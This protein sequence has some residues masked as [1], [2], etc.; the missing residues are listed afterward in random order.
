MGR[1]RVSRL[2]FDLL[3]EV[4][5]KCYRCADVNLN[6]Q[7]NAIPNARITLAVGREARTIVP[8]QVHKSGTD[9]ASF[10]KA[11]I[12][13]FPQGEWDGNDNVPHQVPGDG[14]WTVAGPQCIFEGYVTGVG[15]RKNR[16][17]VRAGVN[18]IHW[19]ADLNFSSAL[20]AESHPSNPSKFNWRAIQ[21]ANHDP[22][23]DK[24]LFFTSDSV[25]RRVLFDL[26]NIKKDFYGIS[27][28]GL[29][30]HLS[31]MQQL[32]NF[33]TINCDAIAKDSNNSALAALARIEK[34]TDDKCDLPGKD[35]DEG[36][37]S[38]WHVPLQLIT[39]TTMDGLVAESIGKYC[40]REQFESYQTSTI[41]DKLLTF[42]SEF[43]FDVVPKIATA[44]IVPS[45][46]GQRKTW[47]KI[48]DINDI[49]YLDTSGLVPRPLR[50]V[51]VIA[52]GLTSNNGYFSPSIPINTCGGCWGPAG[53]VGQVIYKPAPNW[54]EMVPG[55]AHS[56]K[57]SASK[58]TRAAT[59]KG[60]PAVAT[61]CA[62]E[63]VQ[64]LN[65]FYQRLARMHYHTEVLRGRFAMA[66]G[67]LRFDIAPGSTVKI[68]NTRPLF[69]P[70]DVLAD[71]LLGTVSRV[72]IAIS[73]ESQVAGTNFQLD[74]VRTI[75]EA[76]TDIYGHDDHPLYEKSFAGAPLLAEYHFKDDGTDIPSNTCRPPAAACGVIR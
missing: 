51:G 40:K 43:Y 37:K 70:D 26:A 65:S 50:A 57:E 25:G 16:G 5:G 9:L 34:D 24:I 3:L 64:G 68:V 61:A 54:L 11:R 45:S 20:S 17:V 55:L 41:W 67:K 1:R 73:A 22:D 8:A 49:V 66:Q 69:I 58:S 30:C 27:L 47:D 76:A 74:N 59:T 33:S 15:F 63:A 29:F 12:L 4:N 72:S 23:I 31:R 21:G 36:A 62:A 19:L 7:L 42:G 39:G 10:S 71:S 13:F 35:C 44:Q 18:L 2:Q 52:A 32:N 14:R 38:P 46:V 75:N 48:L 56:P 53:A 60:G 28:H 6:F